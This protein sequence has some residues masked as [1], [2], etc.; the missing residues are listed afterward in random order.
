MAHMDSSLGAR[1][2]AATAE[3]TPTIWGRRGAKQSKTFA[4]KHRHK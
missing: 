4:E 2:E 3:I 1:K